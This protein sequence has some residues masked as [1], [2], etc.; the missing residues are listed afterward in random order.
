[1]RAR[2]PASATQTEPSPTATSTGSPPIGS[3]S[4]IE[5]VVGSIR[6]SVPVPT[7]FAGQQWKAGLATTQTAFSPTAT[8]VGTETSSWNDAETEPEPALIRTTP[9]SVP[10]QMAPKPRAS[11]DPPATPPAVPVLK[12]SVGMPAVNVF[13]TVFVAA[14]TFAIVSR[15]SGFTT[16]T[17][18][19]SAATLLVEENAN[20]P[21]PIGIFRRTSF[22]VG[23]IRATC[24]GPF[25]SAGSAETSVQTALSPSA[26]ATGGPPTGAVRSDVLVFGSM[27]VTVLSC[28]LTTQTP[29]RPNVIR[30][31]SDPSGIWPTIVFVSGSITPTESGA[32]DARPF[33]PFVPVSSMTATPI[34][35][36]R[37][38]NAPAAI[39]RPP[40]V[41]ARPRAV[42][43]SGGWR[44]SA[45]GR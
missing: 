41:R 24:A 14:S 30:V 37:R 22:V 20:E 26:I 17:T 15:S 8:P 2:L 32:T 44:G 16:H 36:A 18:P 42:F 7:V 39:R 6:V 1:M 40:L 11:P 31:G 43:R 28:R 5:F 35:A 38:I 34:A 21:V 12:L 10:A 3:F 4:L 27:R 19:F 25:A 45:R 33:V 9:R 29:W 23:S 13:L